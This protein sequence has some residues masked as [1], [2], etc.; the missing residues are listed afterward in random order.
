MSSHHFASAIE[1][2]DWARDAI[3]ELKISC[4]AFFN[5]SNFREVREFDADTSQNI[6]KIVLVSKLPQS[7]PEK[8]TRRC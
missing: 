7:I 2:L 5:A 6:L 3:H 1:M 4:D 8:Q